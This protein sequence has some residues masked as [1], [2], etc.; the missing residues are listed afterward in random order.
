MG[1]TDRAVIR[2]FMWH[3]ARILGTGF[4]WGNVM[5]MAM[6]F[7]QSTWHVIPLDPAAYY[8]DTVPIL[9]DPARIL[10]MEVLAFGLCVVAML[11]PSMWSTRI[12]PAMSLRMQ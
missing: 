7:I 3:A 4:V 1:M 9:I 12:R 11:L 8:V 6:L 10:T 2:T 5:G